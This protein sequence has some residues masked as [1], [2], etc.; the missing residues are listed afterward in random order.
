MH[1]DDLSI[2]LA[3]LLGLYFLI[4]GLII[5]YRRKSLIPVV[6][7][8][9]DNRA[10]ILI[11]ALVE[12]MGGLA[13]AIAHPIWTPDWR[14]LITLMGWLMILESIIYI[15]LPFAGMRRLIRMFNKSQW[16]ISGGFMA[17]VLGGYL[18]AIGFGLI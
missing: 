17:V 11:I 5:M 1:M 13:I 18:A 14:G 8:F 6:Y 15:S 2:F 7:E 4:A 9:I 3:Q 12:L 10:L 16:Y